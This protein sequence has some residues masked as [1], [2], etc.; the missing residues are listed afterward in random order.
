MRYALLGAVGANHE[1]TDR[2][3]ALVVICCIIYLVVSIIIASY[4]K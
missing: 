3:I 1:W 2:E 4:R